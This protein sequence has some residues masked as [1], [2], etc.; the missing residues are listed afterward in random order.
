MDLQ[1]YFGNFDEL[2]SVSA[3]KGNEDVSLTRRM[4]ASEVM[5][6]IKSVTNNEIKIQLEFANPLEVSPHDSLLIDINF[7][8]FNKGL[9]NQGPIKKPCTRQVVQGAATQT[10]AAVA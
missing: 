1:I 2:F 6:V 8:E 7:K 5:Q 10:V 3:F 4:L 9:D